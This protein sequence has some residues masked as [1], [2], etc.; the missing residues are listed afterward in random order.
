MCSR[1]CRSIADELI[2][3][4]VLYAS[5]KVSNA[6]KVRPMVSSNRFCVH[7][8]VNEAMKMVVG[9]RLVPRMGGS[10]VR[11]ITGPWLSHCR[12]IFLV[13]IPTKSTPANTY[14]TLLLRQHGR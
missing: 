8:A 10:V 11:K 4:A 2:Q 9:A 14:T 3:N 12:G 5:R 13:P 7:V 6:A 1:K